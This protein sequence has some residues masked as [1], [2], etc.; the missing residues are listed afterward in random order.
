[1]SC[2]TYGY[3]TR[4]SVWKSSNPSQPVLLSRTRARMKL[5]EGVV[6]LTGVWLM[7]E[8]KRNQQELG[9]HSMILLTAATTGERGD[10]S[11][12]EHSKMAGP[13][14][15][16][17]LYSIPKLQHHWGTRPVGTRTR[18][19][20]CSLI[21]NLNHVSRVCE[22]SESSNAKVVE[23]VEGELDKQFSRL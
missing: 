13:T 21:R 8:S 7:S 12:V 5:M 15:A 9:A 4:E 11:P 22:G 14:R 16:S 6:T 18:R 20:R 23:G 1:M 10:Q 2:T 17:C 3:G 19:W